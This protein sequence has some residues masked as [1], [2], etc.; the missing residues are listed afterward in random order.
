MKCS[1]GLAVSGT[2]VLWPRQV[3]SGP[4]L[5]DPYFVVNPTLV[6]GQGLFSYHSGVA[7]EDVVYRLR[8]VKTPDDFRD[9]Y[10]VVYKTGVAGTSG[11]VDAG[12]W[13]I[14]FKLKDLVGNRSIWL[15]I[16][17][18]LVAADPG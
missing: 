8:Y 11:P 9:P 15:L 1:L 16:G 18:V 14:Y 3:D 17:T 7:N 12:R 4:D 2:P 13:T 5:E 10:T 6:D